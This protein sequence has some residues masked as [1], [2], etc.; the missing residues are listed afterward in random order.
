MGDI[1]Q[2]RRAWM[3]EGFRL[4]VLLCDFFDSSLFPCATLN[5]VRHCAVFM[6]RTGFVVIVRRPSSG[7]LDA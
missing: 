4:E 3:D 5:Y 6:F 1:R 7:S 2:E